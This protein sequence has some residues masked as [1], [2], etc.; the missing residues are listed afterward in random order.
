MTKQQLTRK[1]FCAAL[2]VLVSLATAGLLAAAI[3]GKDPLYDDVMLDIFGGFPPVFVG[4]YLLWRT[5]V[6]LLCTTERTVRRTAFTL[7][8]GLLGLGMLVFPF[9]PSV[10]LNVKWWLAA[11]YAALR[12]IDALADIVCFRKKEKRKLAEFFFILIAL[13]VALFLMLLG[14][15]LWD[16][17]FPDDWL[18]GFVLVFVL[19]LFPPLLLA[20]G[21]LRKGVLGLSGGTG[22]KGF[23]FLYAGL[24][25]GIFI[26]S[27]GGFFTGFPFNWV[28]V[29]VYGVVQTADTL[30]A[31]V[32]VQRKGVE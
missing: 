13:T 5:A 10:K 4:E 31:D 15:S 11:A 23:P 26:F 25:M 28:L 18:S 32:C 9:H 8:Y 30:L 1:R 16:F 7:L 29:G 19:Y 27:G 2:Y 6:Y 17:L 20:E 14:W 3:W 21:L 12:G 24:A 22:G